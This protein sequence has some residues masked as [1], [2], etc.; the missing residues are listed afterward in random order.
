MVPEAGLAMVEVTGHRAPGRADRPTG[1]ARAERLAA[2]ASQV[3]GG[4]AGGAVVLVAPPGA[5]VVDDGDLAGP[6]VLVVAP[7]PAVLVAP[8]KVLVVEPG[9]VLDPG[10][11][12]E[13]EVV[14]WRFGRV[15]VVVDRFTGRV[16]G[17]TVDWVADGVSGI[18]DWA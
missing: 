9:A 10:C 7:R 8:G 16:A 14:V 4:P 18:L 15:D 6:V 11:G 3:V 2:S 5:M 13:V 1:L 12:A 17:D